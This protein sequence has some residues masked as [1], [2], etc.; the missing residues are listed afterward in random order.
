M[1]YS[2]LTAWLPIPTVKPARVQTKGEYRCASAS[3]NWRPFWNYPVADSP[4]PADTYSSL[5]RKNSRAVS[6][7]LHNANCDLQESFCLQGHQ[8]LTMENKTD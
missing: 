6:W 7:E 4:F 8:R 3:R 5:Q 2:V 1:P